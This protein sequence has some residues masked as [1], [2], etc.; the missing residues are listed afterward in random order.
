MESKRI[1]STL[2]GLPDYAAS[3]AFMCIHIIANGLQGVAIFYLYCL[4]GS[5]VRKAVYASI[6]RRHLQAAVSQAAAHKQHNNERRLTLVTDL[7][8]LPKSQMKEK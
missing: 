3:V 6:K 2:S 5:K 7:K 8:T 4:H 1:K